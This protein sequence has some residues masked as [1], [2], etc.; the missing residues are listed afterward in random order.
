MNNLLLSSA[1][2]PPIE[3]LVWIYRY[4]T[5][6]DS[7]IFIEQYDHYIKQTYRNRCTIF[8]ANGPT[9]LTI[10]I[11]KPT[12]PDNPLYEV[13]I[14][15]H[16]NWRHLHWNTLTS[17]Y[18]SSPFFEY[19]ADDFAPFYEKKWLFL[20]DYNE[21]LLELVCKNMGFT[22]QLKRTEAFGLNASTESTD[23]MVDLRETIHPK[24]SVSSGFQAQPYYQVFA[25]KHGFQ[26]NLSCIDLLFQ[27]GPESLLIL[28]T[29]SQR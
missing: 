28:Q 20:V 1:Y 3:Y 25:L 4:S 26:S 8:A 14:S 29:H 10:P 23:K 27:M 13:R 22:P 21:A 17:A 9:S 24:H 5:Q 12:R 19:Y 2:L 18:R 15:D 6:K 7:R 16:G 11:E